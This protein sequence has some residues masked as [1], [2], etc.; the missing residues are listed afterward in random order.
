MAEILSAEWMNQL[1]DEWNADPEVK[2]ALAKI[3]F[4]SVICCGFKDEPNPRGVFIVEKGEAVRAGAWNG[5]EASW[6]MRADKSNWL[7][8]TKDPLGMASMGLAVTMG[9]LKFAKGDFKAMLKDPSMAG[10]FV[11]SFGLMAKIGGE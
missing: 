8:W 4:S 9:K 10:P 5:E 3:N 6:D 2:D 11:K 7:K 1:K